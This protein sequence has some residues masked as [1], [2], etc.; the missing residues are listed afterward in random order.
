M[1]DCCWD[2]DDYDFPIQ[3]EKNM[4]KNYMTSTG[5]AYETEAEAV[6]A[7]KKRCQK[8]AEDVLVYKAFKIVSTTTPNVEIKDLTVA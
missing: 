8:H 7:A 3:K 4:S 5:Y 6:D 1:C 2:D